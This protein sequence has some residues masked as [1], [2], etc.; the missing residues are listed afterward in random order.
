MATIVK[1]AAFVAFYRFLNTFAGIADAWKGWI[2]VLGGLTILW[3]NI[4]ALNQTSVKRTLAFSSIAHAGYLVMFL[5]MADGTNTWILWFYGLAYALASVLVFSIANQLSV[6][7][8]KKDFSAFNGL[9]KRSPIV[10]VALVV[11]VL[12]MAGIPVSAGFNAKFYLFSFAWQHMPWLVGIG[13]LGS[14]ISVGYYFKFFKHAFMQ[15]SE[16]SMPMV[17]R[18]WLLLLASLILLLGAMPWAVLN[19]IF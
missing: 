18:G 19:G 11:G 13:L 3:G 2:S 4:A 7:T 6:S 12:S 16:E 9:A 1:I 17:D 14:A 10:G 5:L 8:G 15:E